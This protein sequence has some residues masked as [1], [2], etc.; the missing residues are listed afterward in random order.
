MRWSLLLEALARHLHR[1]LRRVAH[2]VN[3]AEREVISSEPGFWYSGTYVFS[4]TDVARDLRQDELSYRH[5][6]HRLLISP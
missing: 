5:D 6:P 2:A 3:D 1:R 4:H